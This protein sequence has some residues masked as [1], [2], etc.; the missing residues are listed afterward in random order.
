MQTKKLTKEMLKRIV[1]QEVAKFGAEES[2]E[3]RAK[4]T[5]EVDADEYADALCKKIDYLKAL[6]IKES[7]LVKR[8]KKIREAKQRAVKQLKESK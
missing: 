6:K 3:D 7:M 4:E 1:M 2:T 8:L 5:E